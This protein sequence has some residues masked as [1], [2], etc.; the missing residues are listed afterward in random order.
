MI[1]HNTVKMS[2]RLTI[3]SIGKDGEKLKLIYSRWEYKMVNPL[4]ETVWQ[5]LEK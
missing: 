3:P 4:W 1:G 2:E 5:F